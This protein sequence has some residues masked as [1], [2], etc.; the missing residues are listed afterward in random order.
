MHRVLVV[1]GAGASSTF[2]VHAMRRE[3]LA[4]GSSSL[5]VEAVSLEGLPRAAHGVALV[6]VANHLEA[7][8]VGIRSTLP[9]ATR[10]EVLPA[11][12]P[13]GTGPAIAVDIADRALS[14]AAAVSIPATPGGSHA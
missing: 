11:L 2:L 7:D 5:V 1:C 13:M 8:I 10:I 9:S 6:L 3:I 4:R 14:P 12:S